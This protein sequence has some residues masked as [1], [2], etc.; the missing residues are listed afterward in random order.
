[1]CVRRHRDDPETIWG[2]FADVSRSALRDTDIAAHDHPIWSLRPYKVYLDT[3]DDVYRSVD[4][5]WKNFEK[6]RLARVKY[7]FVQDYD[8]WKNN[9][10][11]VRRPP[12]HRR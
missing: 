3:P 6:E 11:V 1:M 5:I 2:A 8:G 9:A 7:P 4:Y 10:R 12:S